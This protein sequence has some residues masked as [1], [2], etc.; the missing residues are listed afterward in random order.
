MTMPAPD[1]FEEDWRSL[2][3][4]LRQGAIG[5]DKSV[6]W[7]SFVKEFSPEGE[8]RELFGEQQNRGY[9]FL[10]SGQES[11]MTT[12][13]KAFQWGTFAASVL[14]KR[15]SGKFWDAN[16]NRTRSVHLVAYPRY[17]LFL[18]RQGLWDDYQRFCAGFGMC[19]DSFTTAKL[20]YLSDLILKSLP[21]GASPRVLEI[22][23]GSG[24]LAV[25]LLKR[26]RISSYVIVDLPEMLLF[27]SKTLRRLF[28]D[29]PIRFSHREAP[30]PL[31]LPE[32]GALLVTPQ[33]AARLPRDAFDLGL[34]IDSFQEMSREQVAGY[35]ALVQDTARKGAIFVTANRRKQVGSFDSNPL[36]YP[37]GPNEVLLWETDPFFFEV[38]RA[39]RRDPTLLRVEKI[40]K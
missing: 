21:E 15:V 6:M 33:D 38:I 24:V 12:L 3:D 29:M 20:F 37:Y 27:S 35:L 10:G 36:L 1:R 32:S 16:I 18:K 34:N 5:S 40:R 8:F 4:L 17:R 19:P 13:A 26:A 7:E 23:G 28:P 14:F 11:C 9:N 39:D 31:S 25:M 2:R 30:G 22:G